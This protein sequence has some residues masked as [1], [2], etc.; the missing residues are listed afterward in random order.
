MGYDFF[1]ISKTLPLAGQMEG[2]SGTG[3]HSVS[4]LL[5]RLF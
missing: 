4:A 1:G 3:G 5:P 2:I